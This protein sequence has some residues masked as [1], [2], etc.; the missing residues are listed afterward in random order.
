M[1][2]KTIRMPAALADKW[3][4]AL[5]S[6]NYKQEQGGLCVESD[7]GPVGYCCLGVL[8]LVA[9]GDVERSFGV[10][11][12][13]PSVAWLNS[14]GVDFR[15]GAGPDIQS[16][17]LPMFGLTA[18]SANDHGHSFSVIADAIEDALKRT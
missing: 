4:E 5:R 1:G 6:G 3:L 11:N 9:D 17:Y 13:L 8:Q 18:S 7:D 16:P 2:E 15:V 10:P 12:A 14:H